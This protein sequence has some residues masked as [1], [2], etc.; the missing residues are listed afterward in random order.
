MSDIWLDGICK[1]CGSLVIEQSSRHI[2]N[3]GNKNI[4]TSDYMNACLNPKCKES[5]WH[6][7]GDMEELDYYK[8]DPDILGKIKIME[9]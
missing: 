6:Y 5:K 7:I 2:P 3:T 1:E 8:H 9:K 4:D